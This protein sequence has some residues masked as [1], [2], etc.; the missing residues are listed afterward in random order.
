MEICYIKDDNICSLYV[1]KLLIT[2]VAQSFHFVGLFFFVFVLCLCPRFPMSLDFPFLISLSVF[3]NANLRFRR[4]DL[5]VEIDF[6]L[7]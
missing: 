1:S 4:N 5:Y 7:F 2:R 6:V 3:Y